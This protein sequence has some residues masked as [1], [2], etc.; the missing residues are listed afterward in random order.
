MLSVYSLAE[1]GGKRVEGN[2]GIDDKPAPLG[3]KR[4]F[5]DRPVLRSI[6]S[7]INSLSLLE[8][9]GR[10]EGGSLLISLHFT[11]SSCPDDDVSGR[12]LSNH[13]E[14]LVSVLVR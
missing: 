8:G 1:Y 5:A 9:E 14:D 7:S 12:A 6:S 3:S 10:G 2:G 4:D 13:L 11:P